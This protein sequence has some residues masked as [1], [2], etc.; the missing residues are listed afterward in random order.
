MMYSKVLNT[1]N[2][3][4]FLLTLHVPRRTGEGSAS[5][6]PPFG[7]QNYTAAPC[8]AI[9]G[10]KTFGPLPDVMICVLAGF[11]TYTF[12]YPVAQG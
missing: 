2:P 12:I 9:K 10:Y 8:R 7:Y 3:N 1:Y 4:P 6:A 11:T 5:K